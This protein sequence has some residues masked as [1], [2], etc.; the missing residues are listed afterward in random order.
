METIIKNSIISL[1]NDKYSIL[2]DDL[3]L[4]NPPKKEFWDYS[5]NAWIL[6]KELKKSP[7]VIADEI[8]WDIEKMS[9]VKKV[10]NENWFINLF[11]DNSIFTDISSDF[12]NEYFSDKNYFNV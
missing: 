9:F 10:S 1:I 5:F 8:I 2:L 4:K 11:I 12:Y 7:L 3:I 6:S